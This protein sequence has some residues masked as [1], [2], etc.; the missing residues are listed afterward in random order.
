MIY[1]LMVGI[2]EEWEIVKKN[3]G[4]INDVNNS[5]KENNRKVNL[6]RKKFYIKAMRSSNYCQYYHF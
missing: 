3:N 6:I 5:E 1:V 2:T 4:N